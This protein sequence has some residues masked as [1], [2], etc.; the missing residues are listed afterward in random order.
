M[1][2]YQSKSPIEKFRAQEME[3]HKILLQYHKDKRSNMVDI[4][5]VMPLL[6]RSKMKCMYA[7]NH[8]SRI[9]LMSVLMD[10]MAKSCD[11]SGERLRMITFAPARY[12]LNLEDANT[13]K[14]S[15]M[16]KMISHYMQGHDYVGMIEPAYYPNSL[17]PETSRKGVIHWHAHFLSW[18]SGKVKIS[19]IK[20]LANA[21]HDSLVHGCSAFHTKTVKVGEVPSTLA[22]IFKSPRNA[23]CSFISAREG[24]NIAGEKLLASMKQRKKRLR[25]GE[26][27]R[28]ALAMKDFDLDQL[29]V[30]G[31]EGK[32]FVEQIGAQAFGRR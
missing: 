14:P 13:F 32:V 8:Y 18:G 28:L 6:A 25:P 9:G 27:A 29:L 26:A 23:Y 15:S 3:N 21:K 10:V 20:K 17:H 4:S 30:S 5:Q 12:A 1:V 2:E 31:G 22:Y 19:K 24:Q 7:V 16:K 11:F